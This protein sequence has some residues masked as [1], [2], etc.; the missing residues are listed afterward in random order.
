MPLRTIH[1]RIRMNLI[2]ILKEI[3][4]SVMRAQVAIFASWPMPSQI[5]RSKTTENKIRQT[6]T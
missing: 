5:G 1:E 4:Q 2:V 3:G 6:N